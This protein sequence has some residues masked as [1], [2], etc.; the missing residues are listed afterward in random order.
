VPSL[1]AGMCAGETLDAVAGAPADE[2]A[3]LPA[4]G[5]D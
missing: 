4:M 5:V 2:V 3:A 1:A